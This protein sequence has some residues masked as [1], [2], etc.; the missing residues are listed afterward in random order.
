MTT[1]G[2]PIPLGI[3]HPAD[4]EDL[5]IAKEPEANSASDL[6]AIR[7][8]IEALRQSVARLSRAAARTAEAHPLAAVAVISLGL[9]ALAGIST[10]GT[11][12]WF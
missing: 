6:E 4:Y 9:W 8:Q 3:I 1:I 11:R 7:T 2:Q 10:R 5:G 12:R